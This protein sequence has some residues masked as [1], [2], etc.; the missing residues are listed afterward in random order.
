MLKVGHDTVLFRQMIQNHNIFT[1]E[2]GM[3]RDVI[4]EM[5]KIFCDAGVNV[6]FGAKSYSLSTNQPYILL[7]NLKTKGFCNA[8]RLEG[9]DMRH[10]KSVIKKLAQWHAASAVR[11]ATK[12][13]YADI[14]AMGYLR[15]NSYD[16][17]KEMFENTTKALLACVK[18]YSNCDMYYEK[19]ARM[20]H[21]VTDDIFK[22]RANADDYDNEEFMVLNHGDAWLNNIMFQYDDETG[23][24]LETYFVDYQLPCYST[25][26]QDLLYFIMTSCQYE[27]KLK[28]FDYMI[29]FYHR[30]L[31]ESLRL[32]SYSKKIPSLK[33]I[34]CMLF[35]Y[36]IWGMF[37]KIYFEI[38]T[39]SIPWY[40]F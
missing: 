19:I 35:K 4:P 31:E 39:C 34:H 32:L 40:M 22:T 12:G 3:Y 26:A 5:E 24:I 33:D 28:E 17:I 2:A 27:I 14:Y 10:V 18:D 29:A 9:L 30:N 37:S 16:I 6:K 38:I 25:P 36:G 11:V 13:R 20:Q 15:P 7:E 1:V 23:N 21:R 8:N